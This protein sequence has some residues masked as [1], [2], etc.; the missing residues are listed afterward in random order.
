MFLL[1]DILQPSVKFAIICI[2]VL[3]C[4]SLT[5][6][7]LQCACTE[8]CIESHVEKKCHVYRRRVKLSH[9]QIQV[10]ICKQKQMSSPVGVFDKNEKFIML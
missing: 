9:P 1:G 4:H 5:N 2:H 8:Y 7:A 3:L 6:S 10:G